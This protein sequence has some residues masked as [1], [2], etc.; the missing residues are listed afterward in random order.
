MKILEH[1]RQKPPHLSGDDS[2]YSSL[3][4]QL[5]GEVGHER[6]NRLEVLEKCSHLHRA[7]C[8]SEHS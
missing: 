5:H 3:V 6:R 7:K 1:K 2:T 4:K 8:R